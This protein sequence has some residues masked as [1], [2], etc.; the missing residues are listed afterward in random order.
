MPTS[1]PGTTTVASSRPRRRGLRPPGLRARL[2]LWT[3]VTLAFSLAAGF[4]WVHHALRSVLEA[5]NDAFLQGK[6]EELLAIVK[7]RDA[8]EISE[9]EA[10]IR[11]EVAAYEP[12][13]LIV[14]VR[15]PGRFVVEPPSESARRLADQP[16]PPG[17]PRTIELDRPPRRLRVLASPARAGGLSIELAISLAETEA[18]IAAFDRTVAGGAAVFLAVA[19]AG[20]LFL[21]RKALQ[22]VSKSTRAAR[23]LK[24]EDLS[25]R[26]PLTG[27]GDELDELA[28]AFN[29]LLD[30]LAAYHTQV[31]RF[32]ADASHELRSPLGAMRAAI[33]VALQLP[34]EA[35]DYRKVLATLGEQ[36]ERLTTLVNGL[37]LLART[38]A[39][40]VAI[41]RTPVDLAALIAEAVETFEPL[42]EENGVRLEACSQGPAIVAADPSRLRQLLTNLLDNAIQHTP[43]GGSVTVSLGH[44]GNSAALSVIDTGTG[45]LADHLEHIFERFY[46]VDPARAPGGCGLG[47][48]IC[49]W[50]VAAH[51][52]TIAARSTP[53]QGTE[54]AVTLPG[55][56]RSSLAEG[57]AATSP[58]AG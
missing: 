9:L 34:R 42:A 13:G 16:L 40:E 29:D 7:G 45:I 15:T 27:A 1:E 47:L 36:C 49:R 18:T 48:S 24:P 43:L 10:E 12:T 19:M 22:P 8:G 14:V 6:A 28:G 25:A 11:R 51:G 26:L 33:D 5:R 23:S 39:G 4:T 17:G 37:L 3:A 21:S 20:G 44:D 53:G 57:D 35:E 32:T 56:V 50:I 55:P 54:F 30:R 52:G 31:T 58:A 46:R 38:D 41:E 2:A